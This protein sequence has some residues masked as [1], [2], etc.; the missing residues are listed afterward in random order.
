MNRT[1]L[2]FSAIAVLV[3]S[4][5][6]VNAQDSSDNGVTV[7]PSSFSEKP[8]SQ[9]ELGINLGHL[10]IA[11]D[12]D[13]NFPGGYG[14]GLHLRK[15]IGYNFSLRLEYLYGQQ[16]LVDDGIAATSVI[17]QDIPS[18]TGYDDEGSF[19]RA[20]R[21]RYNSVSLQAV[22]NLGN[23]IFHRA[24]P[25]WGAYLYGGVGLYGHTTELDV[26]SADEAAYAFS[27][28][29]GQEDIREAAEDLLDGVYETEATYEDDG[30]EF[31]DKQRYWEFLAGLGISR[32][33][34]D[35]VNI[36]LDHRFVFTGNDRLDGFAHRTR[37]DLTTDND[38]LHLTTLR[39]AFNIGPKGKSV[40]PLYWVNPMDPIVRDVAEL[41]ARPELDVTDSD[42]DGII[43]MFDQDNN[44][45][46]GAPV[47]T[48]G[49]AL[50]SDGDGIIDAMDTEPY[51][52][53]GYEY[54]EKGMAIVPKEKTLSEQDVERIIDQRLNAMSTSADWYLPMIHFDLDK[55][56]IKPQYYPQLHHV[57]TVMHNHPEIRI[58]V[59]G[60]A[61]QSNQEDYNNVLS[62][63][64]ANSAIQY[65]IAT[66]NL[67]ES[68][69]VLQYGGE[70]A[71]LIPET[72][73][74]DFKKEKDYIN[75]RVEFRIA[76]STDQS[77][78][79]PT[80]PDAGRG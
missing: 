41:K 16:S 14:V 31:G 42:K 64:R 28:I 62:W 1:I 56:F 48:R 32:K 76:T 78:S 63:K 59:S 34:S 69:F 29:S 71:P 75:R 54:D 35:R 43:D 27:S 46:M 61:D 39:I 57:A 51:S 5:I 44:T 22:F 60:H 40:E 67:S 55:Y 7:I 26:F 11:S 66:Y 77:M 21:T 65:L 74:D 19:V 38:L 50:D 72:S 47:D 70:E 37:T 30:L 36:S 9:L 25:I 6:K 15:S 52:P 3:I 79:R 45:P 49:V 80:G 12:L 17:E 58:V 2:K 24:R 20:F 18:L 13:G 10:A 73:G 4:L 53:P 23:T 33:I 68:R 8:K